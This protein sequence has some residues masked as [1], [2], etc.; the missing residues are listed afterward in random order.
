MGSIVSI[1][2]NNGFLWHMTCKNNKNEQRVNNNYNY[3]KYE[4]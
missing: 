1:V 4:N 2:F 3:K